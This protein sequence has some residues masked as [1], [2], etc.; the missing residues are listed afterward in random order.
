LKKSFFEYG[1]P[2]FVWGINMKLK[3]LKNLKLKQNEKIIARFHSS[4]FFDS[5]QW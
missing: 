4:S 2:F 1:L 3:F 5:M